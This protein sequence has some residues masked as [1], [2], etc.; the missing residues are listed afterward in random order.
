M[1]I[2]IT[3]ISKK[4]LKKKVF[5]GLSWVL[6]AGNSYVITGPNGS[7][8]STLIRII[9]GLERPSAGAVVYK[10][11][12]KLLEKAEIRK[13]TGV[14]SP[15]LNLYSRLT[16]FEN[17]QFIASLR[18]LKL[19]RNEIISAI[20]KVGLAADLHRPVSTFS[21]GMRQ[22]L[23]I[24]FALLHK[25]LVLLLDEPSANLDQAGRNLLNEIVAEHLTM[26]GLIILATND[27]GEV[28]R[29]GQSVLRLA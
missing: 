8:K 15:D 27:Q 18:A 19:D 22:R 1:Q 17:L 28:D 11:N 23:K 16:P 10:R 12:E 26:G 9:A 29:Y 25:P 20:K 3:N 13:I 14:I 5:S 21:T 6:E 2:K 24:S 4:Y 7:G